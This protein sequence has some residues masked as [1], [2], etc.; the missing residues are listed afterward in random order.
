MYI[1]V[2]LSVVMRVQLCEKGNKYRTNIFE[3]VLLLIGFSAGILEQSMGAR[4]RVG[5]GLSYRPGPPGYI[6]WRIDSLK[7]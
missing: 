6:G 7:V 5:I 2:Q 4:N 1:R 3:T